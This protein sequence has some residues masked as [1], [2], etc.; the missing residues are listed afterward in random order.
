MKTL[1]SWSCRLA[2]KVL[3]DTSTHIDYFSKTFRINKKKFYVLP[4]GADD[5]VFKPAAAK[6]KKEKF[7]V[8]F[9][10]K[11]IPLQG[12]DV[13]VKAAKLLEKEKDIEFRIIGD[14]QL[15]GKIRELAKNLTNVIF[16][17]YLEPEKLAEELSN[18]DIGLGIFGKTS[19]A[20]RVV[21]NKAYEIMASKVALITGD[22]PAAREFLEDGKD[23]IL[24]RMDYPNA[25]A[26]AIKKLKKDQKLREKIAGSGYSK[27]KELF[28]PK[29][30]GKRLLG[31]LENTPA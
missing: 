27:Y 29:A 25:L 22:S 23:S 17:G 30:L 13:I 16:T 5:S 3:L 21:P 26:D 14:G 7:I 20:G 11:F 19:K 24:C 18:S 31:I 4:I 12:V 1:D 8:E 15:F 28:S 6:K 10:G 9:H 2:D